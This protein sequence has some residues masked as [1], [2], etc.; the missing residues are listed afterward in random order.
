MNKICLVLGLAIFGF[1]NSALSECD[2]A[3]ASVKK[4]LSGKPGVG[5]LK[6]GPIAP[7]SPGQTKIAFSYVKAVDFSENPKCLGTGKSECLQIMDIV[8]FVYVDGSCVLSNLV[9]SQV[10]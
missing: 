7:D 1:S 10:R 5:H 9:N 3:V 8:G 6:A 2:D 4:Q